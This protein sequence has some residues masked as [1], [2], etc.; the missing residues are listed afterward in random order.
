M[1]W[2]SNSYFLLGEAVFLLG[3][4]RDGFRSKTFAP[5]VRKRTGRKQAV[6]ALTA[7]RDKYRWRSE[8]EPCRD[9]A[10]FVGKIGILRPQPSNL[11]R[12]SAG[13][14]IFHFCYSFL[15][16]FLRQELFLRS[17]ILSIR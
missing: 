5:I 4:R 12:L 13:K 1:D 16:H 6:L 9:S 7:F 17:R 11:A 14:D 3:G 2:L 10:L 15:P 8:N